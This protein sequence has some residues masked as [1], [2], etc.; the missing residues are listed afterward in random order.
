MKIKPMAIILTMLAGWVNRQQTEVIEYLLEENKVLREKFGKKRIL[1]ND[2][3]RRRLAVLGKRLGRNVLSQFCTSFSPDTILRWHRELVARKYDGSRNRS[4][5]GRP[6]ISEE[7]RQLI[8][9][10]A[11]EC[12][13]FGCKKITGYLKYLGYKV[14][15]TTVRRI[16]IEHGIDPNPNRPVKTTWREFIQ[17][18]W[19]SLAATDFFTVEVYTL[20]GLTRYMVLFV[21][22]YATRKVEIAG[23]IPQA[24]GNWMKQIARN[25]SD[26]IDGFLKDKRYLIHDR[27]P[28]FTR[29]FSDILKI[30]GV[31][32]VK[33]SPKSPNMT[34]YAERFVR[35]IKSECLEKMLILG[36]S[37]LRHIIS[38]YCDYYHHRRP[39]QGL[40]NNMIEPLPQDEYGKI[41]LEKQ[42]GGLLKSYRRVA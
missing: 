29:C 4:K 9:D 22:D 5:H 1:L 33:I 3:Q 10:M 15:R 30:A 42:L 28:L 37:H 20:K 13:H 18:H 38:T 25:L 2:S 36:E 39:H 34:P 8:L 19:E 12:K 32:T 16:L 6:I 40:D 21:I 17:S 26:P 14:S 41:V 31:K 24:D 27:D 7:I 23:I 11:E 35:T